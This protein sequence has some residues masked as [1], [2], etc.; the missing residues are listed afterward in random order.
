MAYRRFRKVLA[1]LSVTG[2]VAS[3]IT[4][5]LILTSEMPAVEEMEAQLKKRQ[6][7][8]V[9]QDDTKVE[10]AAFEKV[11]S[12]QLQRPLQ[13][14]ATPKLV[15]ATAPPPPPPK[16]DAVLLGTAVE[17]SSP[18][19]SIAW[20]RY[21]TENASLTIRVGDRLAVT[22]NPR[23]QSIEEGVVLLDFEGHQQELRM[24]AEKP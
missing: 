10:L 16:V 11:A 20:I 21:A 15:Q 23:V 17:S 5:V 3:V 18:Q 8:I 2:V 14:P 1:A 13:D 4:A 22:G 24:P 9:D 6:P 19:A 12:R 7:V